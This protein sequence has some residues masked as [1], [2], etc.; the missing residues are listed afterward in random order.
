MAA[1]TA[2]AVAPITLADDELAGRA[3]APPV[4][5]PS[6]VHL[7][8]RV[9]EVP[10]RCLLIGG[11]V[12]VLGWGRD[13][14][15]PATP[16]VAAGDGTPALATVGDEDGRVA[17]RKWAVHHALC[18]V[19]TATCQ[20]GEPVVAL[21]LGRAPQDLVVLEGLVRHSRAAPMHEALEWVV[22]QVLWRF[23]GVEAAHA[24][25][26]RTVPACASCDATLAAGLVADAAGWCLCCRWS[27]H[28]LLFAPA[29]AAG[30]V[31]TGSVGLLAW[32]CSSAAL[33]AEVA[34]GPE[35][36]MAL[37]GEAR[38]ELVGVRVLA[39]G[40]LLAARGCVEESTV[41]RVV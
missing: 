5:A 10:E 31:G 19:V 21:P 17:G 26:A 41:R 9:E 11:L 27:G 2:H 7:L 24:L 6:R 37:A 25:D 36:A 13:I 14:E 28:A 4:V 34:L 29:G 33:V 22:A 18:G 12:D 15:C 35:R 8:V 39:L 32:C 38:A 3:P 1:D 40:T 30:T 16:L 23:H 20:G